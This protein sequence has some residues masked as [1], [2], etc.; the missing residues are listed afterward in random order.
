MT[1]FSK[2]PLRISGV[3]R[4]YPLTGGAEALTGRQTGGTDG[5][6]RASNETQRRTSEVLQ[7]GRADKFR[8]HPVSFVST[9]F[10][11]DDKLKRYVGGLVYFDGSTSVYRASRLRPMI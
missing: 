2:K 4:K 7:A 11:I 9:L 1:S 5:N 3:I 6:E 8:A 10:D